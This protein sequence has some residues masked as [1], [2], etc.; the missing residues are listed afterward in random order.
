MKS[1][2]FEPVSI[3]QLIESWPVLVISVAGGA[4][5]GFLQ[6]TYAWARVLVP[7]FLGFALVPL[8]ARRL[9]QKYPTAKQLWLLSSG[10]GICLVGVVTR[11]ALPARQGGR[12]DLFW[13]GTS[14][15]FILAFVLANRGNKEVV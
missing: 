12:F 9:R 15:V 6:V 2:R 13:I 5:F 11:T 3:E 8:S 7:V 14:F 4:L 1:F 10:A